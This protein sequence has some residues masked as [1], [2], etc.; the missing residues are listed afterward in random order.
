M[1]HTVSGPGRRGIPTFALLDQIV[2]ELGG[3]KLTF[4]PFLS[5]T[6][7]AIYPYGSG[8]DGIRLLTVGALDGT[9]A[10]QHNPMQHV[11]GIYSYEITNTADSARIES[12]DNANYSFAGAA[13]SVG[14]WVMMQE[15]LG[16]VRSVV[17]KY[18]STAATQRE[19]DFRFS[20][21]GYPILEIYDESVPADWTSTCTVNVLTPFIWQ[22]V[23]AT[24]SGTE[25]ASAIV[26]YLNAV[27]ET[28]V[29]VETGLFVATED[30]TALLE[31]GS[32]DQGGASPAQVFQ[33]KIALPFVTGKALTATNVTNIYNIGRKL[34]GITN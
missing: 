9:G 7:E 34:L 11:G 2:T 29:G 20:A 4:W 27:A 13:F 21:T 15:A 25:G 19:Y 17:S 8:T 26:H 6:G 1:S 23:V 12:I 18:R 30:S 24:Y 14:A 28:P 32:R 22:F 10:G 3:T 5:G 33:G 31:I 16:T